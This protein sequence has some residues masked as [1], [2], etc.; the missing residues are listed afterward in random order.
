MSRLYLPYCGVKRQWRRSSF[1]SQK[2]ECRAAKDMSKLSQLLWD[3]LAMI[4]RPRSEPRR[5]GTVF[6]MSTVALAVPNP[7]VTCT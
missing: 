5:Q 6:E 2:R 4:A 7:A 1:R 3:T